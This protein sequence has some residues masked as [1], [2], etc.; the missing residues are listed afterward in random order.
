M[1]CTGR[2]NCLVQATARRPAG[3]RLLW[4]RRIRPRFRW[5]YGEPID[6][7]QV[8]NRRCVRRG[9]PRKRTRLQ[10]TSWQIRLHMGLLNPFGDPPGRGSRGVGIDGTHKEERLARFL[11]CIHRQG[12]KYVA[13]VIGFHHVGGNH[14]DPCPIL[15]RQLQ[16]KAAATGTDAD[17]EEAA[18]RKNSEPPFAIC[19]RS[20]RVLLGL[21]FE[22]FR[23][24]PAIS[25]YSL[26]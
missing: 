9:S 23:L 10:L 11:R 6:L 26:S 19:T 16:C 4:P 13:Q 2:T 7:M 15:R 18:R 12:R 14:D 24:R 22:R 8:A 5:L 21:R 20:G 1:R 25:Q 17:N 3:L